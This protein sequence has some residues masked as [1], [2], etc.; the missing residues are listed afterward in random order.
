M[1]TA[2]VENYKSNGLIQKRKLGIIPKASRNI[3]IITDKDKVKF[4]KKVEMIVRHSSEYKMYIKYLRE[5]IDM[6]MCS[7]FRNVNNK[8]SR[9]ISIEI[10]HEPFT[11]FDI[12]LIV[13]NKWM[14]NEQ[15][16]RQYAIAEE[17][18]KIHYMNQVGLLP[19]S[20][21]VHQLVHNGRIFVPLQA[22]YGNYLQFLE[23]YKE[24]IPADLDDALK[25]KLNMSRD[26]NNL[27]TSILQ[28]KYIYLEQDGIIL[29]QL[30][31]KAS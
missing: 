2:N 1:R 12:T 19:L 20:A 11:L 17:V 10:H 13:L 5:E 9:K 4:I 28:K 30:I 7:Y 18:M 8:E 26:V 16:I 25:L 21:T 27:D 14:V 29:P 23:D 15:H 31:Q 22:I 24:Y 3:N 6:T